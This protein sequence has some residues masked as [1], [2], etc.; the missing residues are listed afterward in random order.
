MGVEEL[1]VL[2]GRSGYR[3]VPSGRVGKFSEDGRK[4]FVRISCHKV[5]GTL[6]RRDSRYC[7]RHYCDG[8]NTHS[9][10]SIVEL[11]LQRCHVVRLCTFFVKSLEEFRTK[12]SV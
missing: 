3:I 8:P 1:T 9:S 7:S 2:V 6:W 5:T 11:F 12:V 10:L 4:V